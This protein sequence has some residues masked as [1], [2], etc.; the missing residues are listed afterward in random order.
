[1]QVET[2]RVQD[3]SDGVVQKVADILAPQKALKFAQNVRFDK[4]LGSA[5]IRDGTSLVGAQ[6]AD[7]YE[8][9]GMHQF[10]LSSGTKYLL[11][12]VD[13]A[14]NAEMNRLDAG[15]WTAKTATL[16]KN[17]KHH[18]LTY[19]DTAL[20][21]NGTDK[22]A[23]EDGASWISSSTVPTAPTA[24]LSGDAGSLD[25]GIHYYKISFTTA[26]GETLAGDASSSITGDGSKAGDLS[27][28]PTGVAN[29]CTSRK[30]YRTKAGVASTGTY[31]LVAAIA[32]NSTTTYQDTKADSSL[33]A[34]SL[35]VSTAGTNLNIGSMPTGKYAI[36]WNDRVYVAGVTSYEDR[37]YYSTTPSNYIIDWTGEG[38]GY[39]DIEPF[40]GQGNITGLA[41][42]PG[43]ILIFKDRSLKRWNGRSTNPDDLIKLGS[44]SQESIVLGKRTVFYFSAGYKE[45]IGFYE[46]NGEDTVK[47][48]RPI[49]EI[50][51]AIS[52]SN[53]TDVAGMSD[54]EFV[55]WSIGDITYD[56]TTYSNA[57]VFYHIDTKTWSLFTFPTEYK[58][59]SPYIDSTTLKLIAGDDDGQVLELFTTNVDDIT[60]SLNQAISYTIQYYPMEFGV[61]SLIK[62]ITKIIPH[63][64][65]LSSVV[66]SY[67]IDKHGDY[68]TFGTTS[69]EY[70]SEINGR[71]A[72]HAFEF[73]FTGSTSVGGEFIGFDIVNPNVSTSQKI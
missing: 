30:V 21:L 5:V 68:T 57:C 70:E 26:A 9:L 37:L 18:F 43:Y 63:F 51:E 41:K 58:V 34:A 17:T 46:T 42:V 71:I 54:G 56:G 29:E 73:K 32:D 67:R 31:Y 7:T 8:M 53:Y 24:T 65:N 49:Q 22:Y 45:S 66:C 1:M 6:I 69:S 2:I 38:S 25:T 55:M 16:T 13:G 20:V 60:G 4:V 50:V 44:P 40:E 72:G 48:S 15:T 10:I 23:S 47:I 64:D 62:E 3:L 28:I 39:I 36:E 52:S 12:V 11:S 27:S 19:L 61:R 14:T 59:F 33:G 35:T